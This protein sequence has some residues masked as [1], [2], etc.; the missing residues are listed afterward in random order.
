MSIPLA[1]EAAERFNNIKQQRN[2][3]N[4]ET[5]EKL[6]KLHAIHSNHPE[7]TR[8]DL[9]IVTGYGQKVIRKY[10]QAFVKYPVQIIR[11]WEEVM[12]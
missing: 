7:Y 10:W 3:L 9:S 1:P 4:E 5:I 12:A 8:Q 11:D 2:G 6:H